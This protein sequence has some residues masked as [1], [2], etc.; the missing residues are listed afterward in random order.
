[1]SKRK[2]ECSSESGNS[3]TVSKKKYLTSF[4]SEYSFEFPC[5]T[6]A[7]DCYSAHCKLCQLE[8]KIGHSGQDDC[9]RHVESM[10]HKSQGN[11]ATK[12]NQITSLF[13]HTY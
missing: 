4:K 10:N 7:K 1:M 9:Q 12:S 2:L 3:V 8:F 13:E 11:A 5:L 6:R